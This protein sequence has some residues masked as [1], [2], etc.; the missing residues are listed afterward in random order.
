VV[1]S[2][3][4]A[5][6]DRLAAALASAGT[7]EVVDSGEKVDRSNGSRH[8][9]VVV[10]HTGSLPIDSLPSGIPVLGV[11]PSD[12]EDMLAAFEAGAQG[13]VDIAASVNE[14]VAAA[15]S[16][17]SG[18]AVVSPPL[19]GPLLRAVVDRRRQERSQL[20]ALTVLTQREREVFELAAKGFSRTDLATELIISPATARTHLQKLMAK[21]GIHSQA[22]LVAMAASCGLDTQGKTHE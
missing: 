13:Y 19:L 14:I 2:D 4:S 18:T 16:V 12:S 20:A 1:L 10:W 8:V 15:R 5:V 21:L 7:A 9:D 17:A 6:A 11:G 3:D 22:E